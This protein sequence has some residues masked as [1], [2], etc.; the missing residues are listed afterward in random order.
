[1]PLPTVAQLCARLGQDLQPIPGVVAPVADV[2]AV[3]V[4]ELLDPTG[5][6]AGGELLLTTGLALPRDPDE[7]NEYAARLHR[8]G[9]VALALG[10]GP[11]HQQMPQVLVDAC[12]RQSLPL[13][14]VP[15]RTPF[16]TI[17]H[18]YW[19]AR[20]LSDRVELVDA[21]SGHQAL[22]R[23]ILADDPVGALVRTL[24]SALRSWA[25]LIS[26]EGLIETVYPLGMLAQAESA[27]PTAGLADLRDIHSTASFAAGDQTVLVFPVPVRDRVAGYLMIGSDH[28][29]SLTGRRL[30]ATALLL[31]GVER[32][33]AD[34]AGRGGLELRRAVAELLDLGQEVL[35][36]R[37]C[38]R[39]G[40]A[41]PDG[42][43]QVLLVRTPPGAQ[44]TAEL[45]HRLLTWNPG[46]LPGGSGELRWF[47]LDAADGPLDGAGLV[48][49]LSGLAGVRGAL[50]AVVPPARVRET[51][52]GLQ[53]RLVG[54]PDGTVLLPA[55]PR[56][57]QGEA[58]DPAVTT[59]VNALVAYARADLVSALAA[60]LRHRGGWDAA[61]RDLGVHRNTLR[62]RVDRCRTV[63][64][65][66][67]DDPDVAAELW[68]LLRGRGLA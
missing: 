47:L 53:R 61:A 3:H 32:G 48:R 8:V 23:A 21:L 10:L 66:D 60:Y 52:E 58:G 29:L 39:L 55:E 6:L 4:S 26:P 62:H 67:L 65:L 27:V 51:R 40:V 54:L 16:L 43:V 24:A 9:V 19:Q 14:V 44:A 35:A 11:V 12:R 25:A 45:L 57:R 37:L 15:T 22:A 46:L 42:A 56:A 13:L 28:R 59:A 5:F 20:T 50:S 49:L 41:Y 34:G 33:R 38:G 64:G 31:L 63:S 36:A 30:M 68:L 1:M 17:T 18:A 7:V 2:T